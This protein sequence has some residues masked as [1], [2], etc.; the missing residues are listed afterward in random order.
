[1]LLHD[2]AIT[3]NEGGIKNFFGEI[4]ELYVK[5][6]LNPFYIPG[7]KPR[8][9]QLHPNGV[10]AIRF[11]PPICTYA[12]W[13][14]RADEPAKSRKI[15]TR[16]KFAAHFRGQA[17]PSN[18]QTSAPRSGRSP[19]NTSSHDPAKEGRVGWP[20]HGLASSCSRGA[21][22]TDTRTRRHTDTRTHVGGI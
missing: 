10:Q 3:N 4:H 22:R 2:N 8:A 21:T 7:T 12:A 11:R 1:M 19:K 6:L 13:G 9:V 16:K 5:S 15:P 17:N 20:A 18:P 14:V